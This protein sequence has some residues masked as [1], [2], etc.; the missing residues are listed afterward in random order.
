[1]CVGG[2]R[3]CGPVEDRFEKNEAMLTLQLLPKLHRSFTGLNWT[4][5]RAVVLVQPLIFIL[6][7]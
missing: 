4:L 6:N 2:M 3:W 5:E 7:L 1:M